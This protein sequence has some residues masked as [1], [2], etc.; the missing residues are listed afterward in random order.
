[1]RSIMQRAELVAG[2]LAG[3]AGVVGLAIFAFLPV[4]LVQ[5]APPARGTMLSSSSDFEPALSLARLVILTHGHVLQT[6]VPWLPLSVPFLAGIAGAAAWHARHG[7]AGYLVAL[8]G[9]LA[10]LM[11]VAESQSRPEFA[12]TLVPAM[13]L[14]LLAVAFGFI[15]ALGRRPLNQ[16]SGSSVRL[17][18]GR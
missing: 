18:G 13:G 7:G 2:I 15:G 16:S 1:M 12:L 3:A 17:A 4:Y 10:G 8:C 11:L 6:T 14:G 5:Q 9:S